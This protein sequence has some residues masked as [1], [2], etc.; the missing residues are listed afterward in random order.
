MIVRKYILIGTLLLVTGCSQPV[1]VPTEAQFEHNPELRK[2]WLADCRSGK[3]SNIGAEENVHMC[4]SVES[5]SDAIAQ[6]QADKQV[7]DVFS[8]AILR[9]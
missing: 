6:E 9:K 4:G 7:D 3:Y 1:Q 2:S 8:N 5:A